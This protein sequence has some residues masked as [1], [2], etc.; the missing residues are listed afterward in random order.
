MKAAVF[1]AAGAPLEIVEMPEPRPG[2]GQ[3]LVRV[4][5][6]GICASDL[7]M[8]SGEG[9]ASYATNS[10]FGHEVSGEVIEVGRDVSRLKVGDHIAALAVQNACGKCAACLAGT[11]HFCSA[12]DL[13]NAGGF[14]QLTLVKE[15]FVIR[16]PQTVS[17]ADAALIEPLACSLH[18]VNLAP[19][20]PQS[21]VAVIGAGAI[22]LGVIFWARQMGAGRIAVV[23]RTDRRRA[24]AMALGADPFV[25]GPDSLARVHA[26]LG[27]PPDVVFECSGGLGA[28]A[29]AIN[30]VGTTGTI[31]ALGFCT[32]PDTFIPAAALAKGITMRFSVMYSLEDYEVVANSLD[33]GQLDSR[34]IISDTVGL[35]EFP[36]VFETLRRPTDQCKVLVDPWA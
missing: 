16:T 31:V 34:N 9:G 18:A 30:L 14:V 6:C 27:G 1:K 11:P 26:E 32:K 33:A 4:C 24:R 2:P 3:A 10:V 7:V 8:T 17:L 23:A 28:I 13:G 36:Q 22:G 19:L 15:Q 12:G 25:H 5:R 20:T 29:E 35:D 21:R